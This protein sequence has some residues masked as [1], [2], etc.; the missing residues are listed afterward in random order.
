MNISLTPTLTKTVEDAVEESRF[1]SK[2]EFFR[3]LIREWKAGR[4]AVELEQGRKEYRTEKT[5]KLKSMRAL[6]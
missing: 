3:Y 4:L 6:W 2:S 5:K 1:S